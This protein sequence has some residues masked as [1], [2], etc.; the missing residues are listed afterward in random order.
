VDQVKGCVPLTVTITDTNLIT[1]GE[2]TAG[3]PCLMNAGNN[4]PSQQNQFVITY[5][6]AGTFKLSV[7]YQN[8]GADDITITVDPNIQPAF[9]VYTCSGLQTSIKITNKDY[10]QYYVDFNSDGVDEVI[11]PNGNNQTATFNYGVAGNF[12]ISVRGKDINS[13][14][15]CNAEVVPFT[16]LAALPVPQITTLEALDAT[17]LRIDFT[18]FTNVQFKLEIAVNN[19]NNFQQFQTLY[20]VDEVTIPNLTVEANYYCFRM[21]AYDPCT[22]T[23]TYSSPICSQNFDLDIQSGV[24]KLTWATNPTGVITTD[25]LRD[26]ASYTQILGSSST[27]DDVD[28]TCNT[29]YCYQVVNNYAGG[30]KSISLE[31]CGE[32]FTTTSP[33][34]IDNTSTVV[35]SNGVSLT[36]KPDPLF[37]PLEYTVM[38]RQNG[39]SY[40]EVGKT[41]SPELSDTDYTT[42]SNI[43]YR[44][45]YVDLCDNQSQPGTAVCPIRLFYTIDSKNAITLRWTRLKGWKN[46]VKSY[47]VQKFDKD[48][49]LMSSTN[50]GTDTVSIDDQ[51]DLVNQVNQYR[52]IAE[53]NESGLLSSAS[54]QVMVLKEANLFY[55][56]AFTPDGVGPVENETFSVFGQFISKMELKIFDRWGKMIFFTDENQPWDGT[57]NGRPMPEGTYVW[58]AKITDLAGRNF[59]REGTVVILKR[60]N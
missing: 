19:A 15:N 17:Q 46:D 23:N 47:T 18:P 32:S 40:T 51:L 14:D 57:Q 28:I 4:T 44:I 55:P 1:T 8:I 20:D 7:L 35:G 10:D 11:M 27:F 49:S 39:G 31:K 41:S 2:C 58:I 12:N 50:V 24:N 29:N 43:C 16:S 45:D 22:N 52:I 33:P 6:Q 56:T 9:E 30:S 48:G 36:W 3:K 25:I 13:A 37:T 21:G 26:A 60:Q 54:N 34:A 53:A 5:P 59:S 42:A 38:Q